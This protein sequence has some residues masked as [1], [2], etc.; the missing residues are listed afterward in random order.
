MWKGAGERGVKEAMTHAA[1]VQIGQDKVLIYRFHVY[2]PP[3]TELLDTVHLVFSRASAKAE[4]DLSSLSCMF[5]CVESGGGG[6]PKWYI[7]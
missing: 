6:P 5:L 7:H 2:R 4:H 1:P 3:S